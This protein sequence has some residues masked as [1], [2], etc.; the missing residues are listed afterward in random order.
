MIG[1]SLIQD[2][3]CS[4]RRLNL[5]EL[6]IDNSVLLVHA[7]AFKLG[8]CTSIIV[9]NMGFGKIYIG[10]SDIRIWH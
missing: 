2:V 4:I 6:E 7:A 8:K 10:F 3:Y 9:G 5:K 1:L